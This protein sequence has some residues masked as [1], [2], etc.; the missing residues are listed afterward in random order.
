MSKKVLAVLIVLIAIIVD[1]I[2]KI[3]VKTNFF[4]GEEVVVFDWFRIHFTEN[5]GMAMG[6]ELGG[7]TGKLLLTLFRI[8][9][10]GFIIY[11]LKNTIKRSAPKVVIIAIALILS[12]AIGNIIDSVF[13]GVIYRNWT[14]TDFTVFDIVLLLFHFI[15]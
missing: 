8:V 13:Y 2:I 14:A 15:Q 1:Q 6:I 3:Y 12:G 4:L 9:A 7:K 5:N 10:I 11:W